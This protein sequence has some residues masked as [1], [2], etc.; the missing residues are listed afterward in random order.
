MDTWDDK[1]R[2]NALL[3]LVCRETKLDWR[4]QMTTIDMMLC[5]ASNRH[6]VPVVSNHYEGVLDHSDKNTTQSPG[7]VLH[8]FDSRTLHIVDPCRELCNLADRA[9]I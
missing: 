6:M 5:S 8:H 4:H 9:Q 2:R 7:S 1:D 3:N